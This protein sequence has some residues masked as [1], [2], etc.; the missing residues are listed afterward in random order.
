M[1]SFRLA[2]ADLS[3]EVTVRIRGL[4]SDG[5]GVGNSADGRVVFVPRTAPGDEVRVRITRRK[6]R[7]AEGQLREL[8]VPSPTTKIVHVEGAAPM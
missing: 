6:P 3:G 5:A 2:M 4:S 1:A 7:W 8:L